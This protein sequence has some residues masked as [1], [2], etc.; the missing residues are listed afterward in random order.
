MEIDRQHDLKSIFV[1][2]VVSQTPFALRRVYVGERLEEQAA[3]TLD[4]GFAVTDGDPLFAGVA[5]GYRRC[6]RLQEPV[7][8][9]M[10]FQTE[11]DAPV[12]F[13]RLLLPCA[14]EAGLPRY[15]V[16]MVKMV[17]LPALQKALK[18]KHEPPT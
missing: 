12:L 11:A 1:V 9:Y 18:P 6:A 8:E 14:D 2:E 10:R 13:E 7:Y 16:G 15:L 3:R 5:T 4:F 17:N